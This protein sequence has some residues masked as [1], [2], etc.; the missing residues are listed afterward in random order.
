MAITYPLSLPSGGFASINLRAVNAVAYSQSPFT[1]SG[2][3]HAYAGQ[4][5]EADI[6]LPPMQRAVAEEWIAFLV[7]LRGRFGTFLMGDPAGRAPRG[8]A[9]GTPL[10][11]GAGQTGQTLNIDGAT[12]GQTGWLRA[13]DY[14]Q[15]GAAGTATLHKV[16]A[17]ADSDGSGN[18]ALDI[19][20]GV[21]TSPADNAAV[22]VSNTVG[23]WRLSDNMTEWNIGLAHIYGL[24]FS[25][26]EAI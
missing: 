15:L 2:Q 22:T 19:W 3:V 4:M 18:V 8:S 13:G 24:Q 12:A 21:R 9:G 23:R 7:S 6:S 5:W 16:L 14:I 11:A 25:A 10:V 26:M 17:D 1:Y 20:P